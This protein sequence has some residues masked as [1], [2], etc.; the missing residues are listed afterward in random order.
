MAQNQDVRNRD[1]R[2]L[3]FRARLLLEEGQVDKALPILEAI[4]TDN[5]EEQQE[6]AYFLGWCYVS[7]KRWDDA[8]RVLSPLPQ[9]VEGDGGQESRIDRVRLAHSL[10]RLAQAAVN[11]GQYEDA[12]RHYSKCL[13]VLQNKKIQL[14]EAKLKARYGLA[15]TY[16]MRGL[17]TAAI[18]HYELALGLCLYID[19]DEEMGHIYYGLCQAYVGSGNLINAQLAGEKALELYERCADRHFEGLAHNMLGHIYLKLGDYR[20]ASDHYTEALSLA[21]S[22]NGHKMVMINCASLAE[23]RL[24]EGRLEEARR[25]CQ[26]ALENIDLIQNKDSYLESL[27]Y[28]ECG[29]VAQAE[30]QQAEGERR[31]RLL[32]EAIAWFE[33]TRDGLSPLQAYAEVTDLYGR[34]AE[35]LEQ[36]G[37]YEEALACWK[38]GYEALS[39]AN[40]PEL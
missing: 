1:L 7:S 25:Y 28:L 13:K 33:R 11:L 2:M 5:E 22:H 30:A 24:A 14:P 17:H 39:A 32:E 21:A 8:A 31:Q 16:L 20:A 10:L 36:L 29:K 18:Q 26:R 9:F 40:G 19:D 23:V 3:L 38:S 4:Q 27:T 12:S 35:V 37:R 15:M 34:W 6:I